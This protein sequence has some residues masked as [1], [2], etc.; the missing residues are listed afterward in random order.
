[1]K[2]L[3]LVLKRIIILYLMAFITFAGTTQSFARPYDEACGEY[4]AQYATEF[5]AKYGENSV[6]VLSTWPSWSGGSFG[7]GTLNVCCSSGVLLMYKEALGV[8]ITQYGIYSSGTVQAVGAGNS[9]WD[10]IPMN[11]VKPG[12]ILARDGHMELAV[13]AGAKD[14]ANFGSNGPAAVMHY[15][16]SSYCNFTTAIRLKSDIDV[17][18]NG[19]ISSGSGYDEEQ[20]SIYGANGFIYQG[21]AT[22]SGYESG[23]TL[24]KWLFDTLLKVLDWIIGIIT[25]IVR[26]VI[27]GWIVI[28][29]RVF[30]DGIVNAVTGINNTTETE[31]EETNDNNEE[32]GEN[33]E[34]EETEE[35]IEP[36]GDE[37]NP[38]EYIGTGVQEIASVGSKTQVTTSSEANVTVENIVFN[39]VPILDANFFNFETALTT[40]DNDASEVL[41]AELDEGGIVY[42][43]KTSIATWY[44]T[45]RVMAVAVML[46]I[47]IYLGIRLA[48]TS[49]AEGKAVYKE[50]LM[51]WIAG[52]IL[53]FV[54]H[55]I[56]YAVLLLNEGLVNWIASTQVDQNGDE[57]SLYETVRSKAYE[58]K[59]ST[60]WAGTIMYII[61]VFYAVKFL[62]IYLKR[63]FTLAIL[64]ILSPIVALSYAVEKINKKGKQAAIYGMWLKDFIYT[65]L[66]QS[67]HALIYVVFIGTALELTEASLMGIA[68][69]LVFLNFMSKAEGI[70]KKIMNFTDSS[71]DVDDF[72]F[73]HLADATI[74]GLSVSKMGKKYAHGVNKVVLK[75]AGA[76]IGSGVGYISDKVK[77]LTGRSEKDATEAEKESKAKLT[78]VEKK[79]IEKEKEIKA[80]RKAEVARALRVA[81]DGVAGSALAIGAIPA[82]VIEP[83][84]GLSLFAK[85]AD[86]FIDAKRGINPVPLK[87]PKVRQNTKGKRYTFNGIRVTDSKTAELLRANLERDKIPYTITDGNIIAGG[88]RKQKRKINRK[89]L[90][91]KYRYKNFG[92][93][94]FVGGLGLATGASFVNYIR[95][96]EINRSDLKEDMR[97]KALFELYTKADKQEKE[98]V[99]QYKEIKSRQ[100]ELISAIEKTNPEVAERLRA[101]QDKQIEDALLSLVNPVATEDISKAINEYETKNGGLFGVNLNGIDAA[102]RAVMTDM[103]VKGVATEL[104][105]V[106]AQKQSKIRL[107]ETFTNT[108]KS[109]LDQL[110]RDGNPVA[111][112]EME[113]GIPNQQGASRNEGRNRRSSRGGRD[114]MTREQ[115]ND[116]NLSRNAPQQNGGLSTDNIVEAIK[117][118][119]KAAGAIDV[120]DSDMSE[121]RIRALESVASKIVELE[122]LNEEA[123]NLGENEMYDIESVIK[124]LK[125]L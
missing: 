110:Y 108:L 92:E 40:A 83:A 39:R 19:K 37:S 119:A 113:P 24:G 35:P 45:F 120:T 98:I 15:N 43:L 67:A 54:M 87:R 101:K 25:Y 94:V 36:I 116:P 85:S 93:R 59:A 23:G 105:T 86:F 99:R 6:Y 102:Q 114:G 52:F 115:M 48:I 50:M 81:R 78:D 14:H 41:V 56:M 73:P 118:S 57:I 89:Y 51:G 88:T 123:T 84:I 12:D 28:I 21:V 49:A 74:A 82:L 66:L 75:P 107:N 11:E 64:A 42:L 80:K 20:D 53:L 22:L 77:G 17:N 103:Y 97:N 70:L 109:K 34:A 32:S 16:A 76:A 13:S 124:K 29:E 69:S 60:G 8:D 30:I 100:D 7:Q 2:K 61:L 117:S 112:E 4:L 3:K 91:S 44:Y 111:D 18:P 55:Y 65:T 106:F 95:N 27:I 62:F 33:G 10:V 71:N 125:E 72:K 38:E 58:I 68:L 9:Y 26:I 122:T 46:I 121:E 31:D 1:M 47:L 5:I 104:N 96:S 90:K 79:K 63:Y